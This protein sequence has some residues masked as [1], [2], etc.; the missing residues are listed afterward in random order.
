MKCLYCGLDSPENVMFCIQCGKKIEEQ[1]KNAGVSAVVKTAP[2]KGKVR[3]YAFWQILI[4]IIIS[5]IVVAFLFFPHGIMV[6]TAHDTVM[7]EGLSLWHGIQ[8]LIS[9][10][11]RYNA[12]MLSII[13]G[14]STLL[15]ALSVPFFQIFTILAKIT[16]KSQRG[17]RRIAVIMTS[18]AITLE[19]LMVPIAYKFVTSFKTICARETNLN[20]ITGIVSWLSIV[21]A[22][23]VTGLMIASGIITHRKNAI[24][25]KW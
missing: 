14:F 4:S 17:I 20:D 10:S 21:M 19:C 24:E 8:I 6:R 25:R 9:G 7:S 16:K 18:F 2:E 11:G 23:L 22:L 3:I 5:A 12:T 13:I 1:P 15:F